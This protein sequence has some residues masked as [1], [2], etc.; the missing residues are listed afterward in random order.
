MAVR[1]LG[2]RTGSLEVV[3]RGLGKRHAANRGDGSLKALDGK[4]VIALGRLLITLLNVSRKAGQNLL[5]RPRASLDVLLDTGSMIASSLR[6]SED[7]FLEL[8]DKR[9]ALRLALEITS[10]WDW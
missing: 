4:P 3:Q 6:G 9:R 7:G 8:S 2:K 1:A 10:S 5:A